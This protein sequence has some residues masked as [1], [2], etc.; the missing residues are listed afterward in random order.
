MISYL[1]TTKTSSRALQCYLRKKALAILLQIRP[2]WTFY[3]TRLSCNTPVHVQV[4]AVLHT[5]TGFVSTDQLTLRN[6]KKIG[7]SSTLGKRKEEEEKESLTHY[8]Q[9]SWWTKIPRGT[10]R[11]QKDS[12]KWETKRKKSVLVS[13]RG[14]HL[15]MLKIPSL[16]SQEQFVVERKHKSTSSRSKPA[17]LYFLQPR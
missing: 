13:Q 16:M 5:L 11:L 4:S 15:K 14:S 12:S 2:Q 6:N 17:M 1:K 3:C 10:G 9:S 8:I 7:F